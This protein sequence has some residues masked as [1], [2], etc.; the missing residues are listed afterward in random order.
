MAKQAVGSVEI[1]DIFQEEGIVRDFDDV[2]T[3]KFDG[4]LRLHQVWHNLPVSQW[5][6]SYV[7]EAVSRKHPPISHLT[8]MHRLYWL[9]APSHGPL[10]LLL[11]FPL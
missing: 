7:T 2:G 1:F 8:A 3:A 9:S 5:S 10:S 4:N 11:I 6:H